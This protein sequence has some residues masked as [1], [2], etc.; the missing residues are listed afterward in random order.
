MSGVAAPLFDRPSSGGLFFLICRLTKSNMSSS[1][2]VVPPA[3]SPP[4][5]R[6]D[7]PRIEEIFPAAS[8]QYVLY[9][10]GFETAAN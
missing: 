5:S 4:P 6:F 3:G 10:M 9:G 8:Y 1:S 2:A 7:F